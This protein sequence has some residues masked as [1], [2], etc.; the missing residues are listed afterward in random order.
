MNNMRKILIII[1]LACV[2]PTLR[3]QE[4]PAASGDAK[5]YEQR[6][7]LLVSKLGPAGIGIETV[8][9][10]WEG[11]APS[12][13]KMLL[14]KY[15]YYIAKS[16]TVSVVPMKADRYLGNKPM[17]SLK[18]S[19]GQAVN[20][21]EETFHD[22]SL[23]ST[24]LK[25]ADKLIELFPE[26]MDLRFMKAASLITYEK[27]SPD[28]AVA[29]LAG[30][31][32]D[33]YSGGEWTFGGEKLDGRTFEGLMQEYFYTLYLIGTP[34]SYASFKALSE[35]MLS[36]KIEGKDVFLSN[37]GAY[38]FVAEKD[39]KKALKAYEKVLKA[40]PDNYGAVKNCILLARR[41]DNTKLEK[42]YLPRLMELTANETERMSAK[43]RLE[44]LNKK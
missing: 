1:V 44:F 16:Q 4:E 27:E 42:K 18:D 20:Y 6:Y 36:E 32:D 7:E 35:R 17:L 24:A 30:I 22:D 34:V 29:Y 19:T 3:A 40:D 11:V 15:S 28:M 5:R 41:Q 26:E 39:Y 33:F 25:Y 10:N 9:N 13:R 8:L 23:F 31:I 21:F 43:A 2:M 38:Y 12:D 37:L 14:A